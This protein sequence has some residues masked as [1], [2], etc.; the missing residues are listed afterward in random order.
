MRRSTPRST[1]GGSRNGSADVVS[2]EPNDSATVG[3]QTGLIRRLTM[4]CARDAPGRCSRLGAGRNVMMTLRDEGLVDAVQGDTTRPPPLARGPPA[5][6]GPEREH[7]KTARQDRH[8][9]PGA[10]QRCLGPMMASARRRDAM[11]RRGPRLPTS[12]LPSERHAIP[13][14][15]TRPYLSPLLLRRP[16]DAARRSGSRHPERCA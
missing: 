12:P 7:P 11:T 13:V 16:S 14:Q 8:R 5:A 2:R 10:H 9:Q 1:R 6:H 4:S 3:R 15:K